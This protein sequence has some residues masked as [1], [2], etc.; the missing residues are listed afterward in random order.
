MTEFDEV[1]NL[2]AM[3]VDPGSKGVV[4]FRFSCHRCGHCCTGG[5]G[6][7][8]LDQGEAERMAEFLGMTADAFR[9]MHVRTVPDPNR[10]GELRETL[11]EREEGGGG[12]CTLL[13][14]RNDCSV[15]TARP[16]H[17]RTFPYWP[18]VMEDEAGF[19]RARGTCPGIRLEPTSAQ[20]E[21]AFARLEAIYA[22]LEEL[23]AA[24][25]PVCIARGV[26]CRF[27]E[28]D[29]VLYSTGLE[30]DYAAAK[31]PVAPAPEAEGR[32]PYHVAGRCTAREGRPLGCR[33]YYCDPTLQDALEATHERLLGE[34]RQ[35]ERD[36]D[37]PASYAPFPALLA[38]RNVGVHAATLTHETQTEGRTP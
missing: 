21:A 4:P 23:L 38:D 16:E 22:E 6:H 32:C 9:R 20:R 25:R 35:I 33:T 26:C 12:R 14:G 8:W 5:E 10:G 7:V 18:S 15:Y 13:E 2:G 28:A 11:R 19:E 36:L 1:Q 34:I 24:V 3:A 17:C 29:H 27:E 37:Y 31:K 30:A